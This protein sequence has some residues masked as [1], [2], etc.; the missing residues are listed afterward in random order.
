MKHEIWNVQTPTICSVPVSVPI[1]QLFTF[2]AVNF[3]HPH[4]A[5]KFQ[6]L[7]LNQSKQLRSLVCTHTKNLCNKLSI[8]T[9]SSTVNYI[10]HN[11]TDTNT[12]PTC[13]T[14]WQMN[15]HT[16][17][18]QDN[19]KARQQDNN[20]QLVVNKKSAKYTMYKTVYNWSVLPKCDTS[21]ITAGE[22]W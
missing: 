12:T 8:H 16:T 5:N 11:S 22:F 7:V 10:I 9:S 19:K 15:G 14:T 18:Q 3:I 2:A 1:L 4:A 21:I 6:R 17:R 20:N 13:I